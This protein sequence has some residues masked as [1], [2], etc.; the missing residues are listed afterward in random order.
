M[1]N[2]IVAGDYYPLGLAI[3]APVHIDLAPN[4][5][6]RITRD[7]YCKY[8]RQ[9]DNEDLE[10]WI[11]QG[12]ERSAE[13]PADLLLFDIGAILN[14]CT[15]MEPKWMARLI[16]CGG[17]KEDMARLMREDPTFDGLTM[18]DMVRL[19]EIKFGGWC[20]FIYIYINIT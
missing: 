15:G 1:L 8:T 9:K 12:D 4:E 20:I 17:R 19:S 11:C 3:R 10:G 7:L 6:L 13:S 16:K 18:H 14:V 5:A 2:P